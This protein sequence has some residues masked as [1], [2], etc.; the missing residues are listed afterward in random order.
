MVNGISSGDWRFRGEVAHIDLSIAR[1]I[2]AKILSLANNAR[3][4]GCVKLQGFADLYRLRV[5]DHRIVYRIS[6][7]D[8]YINVTLIGHR[9]EVYRDL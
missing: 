7:A 6:D 5:G 9:R 3:P 2:K 1:R 4:S 8:L